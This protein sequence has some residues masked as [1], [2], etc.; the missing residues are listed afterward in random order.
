MSE[1]IKPSH[2]ERTAYVYIRQSTPHQV[3]DHKEGQRRQYKLAERACELG[4]AAVEVIDEDLGVSGS[5]Y[6][7]RT[8]FNRLLAGVCDGK[9]GAVLALE[10]SRL[11]RNSVEW[12]HLIQICSLAKTIVIDDDGVYDPDD[13]NDRLVLGLKGTLCEFEVRMFQQRAQAAI[14]A[15]VSRGAV[16]T[17]V[18]V[19]YVRTKDRRCEKSPDLEVQEAIN[20]VFSRFDELG[21][22]RQVLLRCLE[23]EVQLPK[24]EPDSSGY[25]IKW[26]KPTKTRVQAILKN[27]VYAGAF[28]HGRSKTKTRIENGQARK[29]PGHVVSRSNWAVVIQDHHEGYI[30]WEKYLENQQRLADNAAMRGQVAKGA[31]RSGEALLAGLLRCGRCARRL[32]VQ[33]RGGKS[34]R[35]VCLSDEPHHGSQWCTRFSATKVDKVVAL[36]VLRA[37][38]PAGLKASFKALEDLKHQDDEARRQA[39]LAVERARYEA[40]RAERQYDAVEPENRNVVVSL[41]RRWNQRLVDLERAEQRHAELQQGQELDITPTE[42]RQLLSLGEDLER[43]WNHPEAPMELKKR[44]IRTVLE[45]IIVEVSDEQQPMVILRLHWKGGSHTTLRVSKQR[46][47]E[48]GRTTSHEAEE[49]IR[50]LAETCTDHQITATLNR[51]GQKT[52]TGLSWNESRV[53]C[54]RQR[55]QIPGFDP[56]KPCVWVNLRKAAEMLG[57]RPDTVRRMVDSGI[58]PAKQVVR[59]APWRIE[60]ADLDLPEVQEAIASVKSGGR[61]P[62]RASPKTQLSLFSTDNKG[63]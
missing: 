32:Q 1:K 10:A 50:E 29:S 57:V 53:R 21:T 20:G 31:P 46:S 60:R 28:V 40:G 25:E 45:E 52:G 7:E 36:E 11:A 55:R 22:G 23:E 61:L 3:R 15:M 44:I 56:T 6:A 43:V 5:G 18:A 16:L 37:I 63:A 17:Q 47:G 4:F 27:P 59:Y 24:T 14:R 48:H 34:A 41:E 35:Y 38:Q 42:R 51:L 62:R 12:N 33:Y 26:E 54:F 8:G 49:L 58:L 19:G 39:E 13:A 30:T 2:L 9:A